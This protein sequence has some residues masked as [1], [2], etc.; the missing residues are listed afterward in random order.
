[1]EFEV[2]ACVYTDESVKYNQDRERSHHCQ[3]FPP[4]FFVIPLS[5]PNFSPLQL[6]TDL[7]FTVNQ[8]TFPNVLCKCVYTV[9][10]LI[11]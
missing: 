1:M 3:K 8:L 10:S 2:T 7:F 5:H 4:H 9:S 6:T 11:Y